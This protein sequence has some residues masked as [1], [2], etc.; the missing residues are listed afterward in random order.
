MKILFVLENYYPFIGGAE[1]LFRSLCEG[2]AAR[3]HDV[4]VITTRLPGTQAKEMLGNVNLTRIWAP[5]KGSR[6]WFTFLA[7]PL[8][9]KLS[10]WADI[11][12]TT[13]YNGAF[14][15]LVAAKLRRRKCL[16]TVH[17][18]IGD[19]WKEFREMRP[20]TAWLHSFLE[21]TIIKLPFDLYAS[22]SQYTSQRVEKVLGRRDRTRVVYDGIDYGLFNPA[23]HSGA[24]TRQ[25]LGVKDKFV[26]MYFG[27]PGISKGVEYLIQ[28]VPLIQL[29][30]PSARLLL[31]LGRE[32]AEGH[33]KIVRLIKEL[34]MEDHVMLTAPVPR[35]EL[36]DYIASADCVIVPSLSEGFGYSAA[37]ACAMDRPVVATNVAS[38]PEVISGKYVLVQPKSPRA[39]ADAVEQVYNNDMCTS[40]KKYFTWESCI[41]DYLQLYSEALQK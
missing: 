29:K 14:P 37:E 5:L 13:T 2:L 25:R 39:I 6:Y 30:I 24:G 1:V 40:P 16:I 22:V 15:A 4:A 3:G 35:N 9:I 8:A 34:G 20:F 23:K 11:I 26:Y 18:F 36:P 28:A 10:G 27:R 19:G 7:I 12:H 17:E 38:L 32:P 31:I 41:H 33:D 21:R